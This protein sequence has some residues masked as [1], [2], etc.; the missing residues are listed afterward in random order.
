MKNKRRSKFTW[1]RTNTRQNFWLLGKK[2]EWKNCIVVFSLNAV[3]LSG[4]LHIQVSLV[5]RW[6]YV[7]G[8]SWTVII[9]FTFKK[10]NF[11][12]ENELYVLCANVVLYVQVSLEY[13]K[14][15][16]VNLLA[17]PHFSKFSNHYQTR[18]TLYWFLRM[19]MTEGF[20]KFLLAVNVFKL[21]F[22]KVH[23]K[24]AKRWW[25]SRAILIKEVSRDYFAKVQQ[26][27]WNSF[28]KL[29]N[30]NEWKTHM[31]SWKVLDHHFFQ[32]TL[33]RIN[34]PHHGRLRLSTGWRPCLEVTSP[35]PWRRSSAASS[36]SPSPPSATPTTRGPTQVRR[37]SKIWFIDEKSC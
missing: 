22:W 16:T 26:W 14:G 10:A 5:I 8:L 34:L 7:T 18:L 17:F 25:K 21:M 36:R 24:Y 11:D 29:I 15:K 33:K 31:K 19:Q 2:S 20:L 32:F 4:I 13:Y 35:D 9:E 1:N 6:R 12:L 30:C 37:Q 23:Q 3:F 28:S 27:T